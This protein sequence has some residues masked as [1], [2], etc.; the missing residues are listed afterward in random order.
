MTEDHLHRIRHKPL[1]E[2]VVS[3]EEAASLIRDGMVLG[4]SGFT[5]AGEAKAVPL[6]LAERAKAQPL[7]VTLMTGASLGNDLDKTLAEAKVLS[8]R[9]PFMS[10]PALR[11]A[12]NAGGVAWVDQ[13][14][15]REAPDS[16]FDRMAEEGWQE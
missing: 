1:R 15:K 5:R 16:R 11:R 14:V 6:A 7:K 8:R 12:I 3:A 10:D 2:R 13:R 9:I 4:M